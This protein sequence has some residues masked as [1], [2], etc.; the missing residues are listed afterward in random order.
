MSDTEIQD[1]TEVAAEAPVV[2]VNDQPNED[3]AVVTAPQVPDN[4]PVPAEAAVAVHDAAVTET[5]AG[6]VSAEASTPATRAAASDLEGDLRKV[7]DDYVSG[8]LKLPEGALPT[9]HTLAAQIAARRADGHKVSSGAV[10]AALARWQEIGFA[11]LGTKPT[12]FI[13]YTDAARQ[14]GLSAL[15]AAHRAAKGAARKAVQEPAAQPAASA[16]AAPAAPAP[17]VTMAPP[18]EAP[19]APA[20]AP[21]ENW[22]QGYPVQGDTPAAQPAPEA[23]PAASTSDDAPSSDVAPF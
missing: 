1:T 3:P 20:T 12:T 2:P 5:P 14:Q 8:V 17:E 9:P 13:D 10:S 18:A 16:P 4:P 21:V 19:V 15:K 7:L 22:E 11:T 23:T 6:A